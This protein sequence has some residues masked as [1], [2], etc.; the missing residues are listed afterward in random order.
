MKESPLNTEKALKLKRHRR[1]ASALLLLMLVLYLLA[2]YYMEQVP[3]LV[4]LK[5]FAE[6]G[7]IGGLADW[8]AVTALFRHP[9]GIPIPH[10]AIIPLKKNTIGKSLGTFVS[11]NFLSPKELTAKSAEFQII[12]K[13]CLWLSEEE[14]SHKLAGS[15]TYTLPHAL[16]FLKENQAHQNVAQQIFSSLKKTDAKNGIDQLVDW[17]LKDERYKTKL[18]P[19]LTQIAYALSANKDIIDAAVKN[20]APLANVPLVRKISRSIAGGLSGKAA[21]NLEDALIDASK[22]HDSTV[23]EAV[24]DIILKLKDQ[25]QEN[26]EMGEQLNTIK[27]QWLGDTQS[28]QLANSLWE[29]LEK[30]LDH[31]LASFEPKSTKQVALL[32]RGLGNALLKDPELALSLETSVMTQLQPLLTSLSLKVEALIGDTVRGWD[33]KEFAEKL[34]VQVGADLQFIRING[35]IIGGIL[36]LILHALEGLF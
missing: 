28:T 25:L 29:K 22:N 5:A 31:D 7:M 10:T 2:I 20:N 33:S 6:A 9:L 23:W 17:L 19:F 11:S 8:F 34:E 27:N 30:S 3:E 32:L 18:S 21:E 35:T 15:I 24:R 1:V 16:D 36:G 13:A 14:N 26:P 12:Q 4:W